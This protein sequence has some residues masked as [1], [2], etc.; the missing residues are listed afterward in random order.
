MGNN[1]KNSSDVT[2]NVVNKISETFLIIFKALKLE[3]KFVKK[4]QEL[5]KSISRLK[6]VIEKNENLLK[7]LE[8]NNEQTAYK[9]TSAILDSNKRKLVSL[10]SIYNPQKADFLDE[11]D[12]LLK[13][14]SILKDWRS[15]VE[16]LEI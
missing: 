6:R 14:D 15:V 9:L 7:I 13:K 12:R 8:K 10:E 2:G 11:A 1:L 5:I 4:N 3:D 16:D